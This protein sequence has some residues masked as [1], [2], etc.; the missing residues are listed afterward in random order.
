MSDEDEYAGPVIE[1]YVACDWDAQTHRTYARVP[2]D[3][4]DMTPD[5]REQFLREAAN[6][7]AYDHVEWG[8]TVHVSVEAAVRDTRNYWSSSFS[9]DQLEDMFG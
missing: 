8:T 9:S 5:T 3:W 6:D 7:Y 4:E 2:D 1:I